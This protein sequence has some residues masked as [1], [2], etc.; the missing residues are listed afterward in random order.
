LAVAAATSDGMMTAT[1]PPQIAAING[2]SV[3]IKG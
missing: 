1:L 2:D 3:S